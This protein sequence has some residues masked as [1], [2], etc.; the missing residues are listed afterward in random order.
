MISPATND[1]VIPIRPGEFFFKEKEKVHFVCNTRDGEVINTFV[2][3]CVNSNLFKMDNGDEVEFHKLG[4]DSE[5]G[6][7]VQVW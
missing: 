4:C 5:T 6:N 3:Q 7:K 2:A 1:F